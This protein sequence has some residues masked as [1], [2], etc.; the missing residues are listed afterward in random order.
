MEDNIAVPQRMP[1]YPAVI[2]LLVYAPGT[3]GD[4]NPCMS[5]ILKAIKLKLCVVVLVSDDVADYVRSCGV[6]N[7]VNTGLMST[8]MTTYSQ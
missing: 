1:D 5:L 6:D 4:I 2:D 8:L 3:M 7:V